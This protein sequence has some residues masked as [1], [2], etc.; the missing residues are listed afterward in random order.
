MEEIIFAEK[1]VS[2]TEGYLSVFDTQQDFGFSVQRIYYTYGVQ[3]GEIRGKHAHKQLVQAI[4]CPYGHIE[5]TVDDGV[6][7]SVYVLDRPDKAILIPGRL[8]LTLQWKQTGSVLC[9]AVSEPYSEEDY[10]RDYSEFLAFLDK[11]TI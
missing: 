4:W 6:S 9:A 3:E 5:I 10:I 7:K 1:H 11:E 2:D 8:W